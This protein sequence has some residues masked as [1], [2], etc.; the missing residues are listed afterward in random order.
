MGM[1]ESDYEEIQG[2]DEVNYETDEEEEEEEEKEK[3]TC[4]GKVSPSDLKHQFL[5][6]RFRSLTDE[7]G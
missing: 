5:I 4:K 2:L 6:N 3:E 7:P 1:L